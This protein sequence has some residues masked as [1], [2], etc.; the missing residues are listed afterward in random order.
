M[1]ENPGVTVRGAR[2][3]DED[4]LLA[5]AEKEMVSQEAL[6]ARFAVRA[7]A[8]SHYVLYLRRQMRGPDSSVFVACRTNGG[9]EEVAGLM[10]AG[11]RRQESIFELR[12][13]G[14]ISDLIVAEEL[15]GRGVGRALYDK[16]GSWIAG[17][18]VPVLRM[19]V[20][21][22]SESAR[23]FWRAMGA[24]P[25]LEECWIDLAPSDEARPGGSGMASPTGGK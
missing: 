23:G 8:R 4:G 13:Y 2:L 16:A 20:A 6:D 21:S 12:R 18:G 9:K 15:R 1:N 24:T 10:V 17:H 25:F 7:D 19:H 11:I 3:S 5:L 22:R 14:Y